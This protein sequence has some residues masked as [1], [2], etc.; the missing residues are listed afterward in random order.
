MHIC[1]KP[2]KP[3][4]DSIVSSRWGRFHVCVCTLK[5]ISEWVILKEYVRLQQRKVS[6]LASDA[7]CCT[8][9]NKMLDAQDEWEL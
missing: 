5:C 6:V 4:D 8:A 2:T 9:A 3:F 1:Q 7:K